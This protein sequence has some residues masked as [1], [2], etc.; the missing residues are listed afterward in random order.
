MK[1]SRLLLTAAPV[2]VVALAACSSTGSTPPKAPASSPAS[3]VASAAQFAMAADRICA[4]QNQREAA[5][6]PGLIN[7]DIVPRARLPKAAAYLRKIVAI[8]TA[9]LSGLRRLATSG[10]AGGRA[11]REAFVRD[12]EK[13]T[14]DYR[15]AELAAGQGNLTAFRASFD[16]VAPHGYP[17]GPDMVALIHASRAFP[18]KDCGKN[19]GL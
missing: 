14:A 12:Y 2:V 15:A 3:A 9:G 13:L 10:P 1:T 16:R 7:A 6:G 17:T 11:A 5:L 8:K 19:A 4:V 18:F